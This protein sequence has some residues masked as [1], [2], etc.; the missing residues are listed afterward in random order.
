MESP[1]IE[2]GTYTLWDAEG[3]ILSLTPAAPTRRKSVLGVSL[4]AVSPGSL[5][6]MGRYEPEILGCV[7]ADHLREVCRCHDELPT[8][9][10][11]VLDLLYR[12]QSGRS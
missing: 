7:I 4:V 12:L 9:L 2:D 11:A 8:E 3:Q 6:E 1:D 10:G 5:T